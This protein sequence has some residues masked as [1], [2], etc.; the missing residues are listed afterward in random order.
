MITSSDT[1]IRLRPEKCM[2]NYTNTIRATF[3]ACTRFWKRNQNIIC[4][5]TSL[6]T[7]WLNGV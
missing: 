2:Y 1:L 4:K 6:T 5:V 7:N 3:L